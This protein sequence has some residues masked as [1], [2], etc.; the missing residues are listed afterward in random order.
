M[1]VYSYKAYDANGTPLRGVLTADTPAAGRQILR[2]KG[3]SIARFDSVRFGIRQRHRPSALLRARRQDRIAEVARHLAL[4]LRSGVS[5]VDSLDVLIRQHQGALEPVLR[6]IREQVSAG[7]SLSDALEQHPAWF[8]RVFTTAV[9]IGQSSGQMDHALDEL[10]AF[11]QERQALKSRFVA[12]VAY[13]AILAILAVGVVAFLM[14]FVVPQLLIVLEASGRP[15]PSSTVILKSISD[16]LIGHWVE[17]TLCAL[18]LCGLF[19]A[20]L[21]W[22]TGRRSCQSTWL[23]LPV[24]GLLLRKALVAQFAQMMSLLLRSGVPFVD[25]VR[26]VRDS[27]GH[28]ILADELG[29]M[30]SAVKRGSDIAPT[31]ERSRVFPPL[32]AHIMHVGQE[33][34]EL[35]EML[36]QLKKG[37]DAEVRLA[38][39][40]AAAVLEPALIVCMSSLIGFVV[41]ATMMPILEVTRTIR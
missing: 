19:A 21:R 10:A 7:A 38:M 16:L 17:L 25:S 12:A 32:A 34:G 11:I 1:P 13:P 26:L 23:T 3:V 28:L 33:S 31:L 9:R 24:V 30:E 37:Y 4:L 29:V 5:I 2:Q 8:D 20:L 22:P 18:L 27:I 39:A 15:L 36:T 14:T 41:F 35:T 6:D 40:K